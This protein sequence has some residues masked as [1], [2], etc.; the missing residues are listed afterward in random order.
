MLR[1]LLRTIR[2][3]QELLSS[4]RRRRLSPLPIDWH[5]GGTAPKG[6][7]QVTPEQ[8]AAAERNRARKLA[9]EPKSKDAVAAT[10]KNTPTID[11][12][13]NDWPTEFT[14]SWDRN[15]RFPVKVK[16]AF[17]AANLYLFYEVEDDSPWAN[18]G[19]DWTTL[20][21]TGDSVDLQFGTN[22]RR[23]DRRGP[24]PGDLRLLIA[25]SGGQPLAVLYQHRVPGA[26]TPVTFTCPW[27][28]ET[29]DVVHKIDTAKIAVTKENNRYRVEASIPLAELGLKEVAG[30]KYRADFGVIY[31]DP[32]GTINQLRSYWSNT[33]T[34]L[35]N[36]V[37]GEIML[38]PNLW[39]SLKMGGE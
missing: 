39:G 20:F 11:G 38:T 31:G 37:P 32:E 10:L 26:R 15:G 34:G 36:D 19:K 3:G 23:V 28:S 14:L 16:C 4:D 13:D 9:E 1:W 22:T 12:K 2:E 18:N 6:T 33:A 5:S 25:P 27:R 21:K 24:V 29:V 30:K 7:V 8:L 17:D 35:V